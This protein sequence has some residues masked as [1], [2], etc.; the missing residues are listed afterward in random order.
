MTNRPEARSSARSEVGGASCPCRLTQLRFLGFLWVF[1]AFILT[2]YFGWLRG[3]VAG[4]KIADLVIILVFSLIG[5]AGSTAV[6]WFG[7][8]VNTF[9]NSRTAFAS[10]RGKPYP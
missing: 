5:I 2:V 4:G 8:R 3:Y 6:A 10:L 1:I 9:A 7:I